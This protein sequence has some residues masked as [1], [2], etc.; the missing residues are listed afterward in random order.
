MWCVNYDISMFIPYSWTQWHL[1]PRV[2]L[3]YWLL[4]LFFISMV[5]VQCALRNSDAVR[6]MEKQR[7]L[8]VRSKMMWYHNSKVQNPSIGVFA[9]LILKSH[10][11]YYTWVDICAKRFH[12]AAGSHNDGRLVSLEKFEKNIAWKGFP[13]VPITQQSRQPGFTGTQALLPICACCNHAEEI[14]MNRIGRRRWMPCLCWSRKEGEVQDD[15]DDDADG[16]TPP[17][18]VTEC[19]ETEWQDVIDYDWLLFFLFLSPFVQLS[20][21]REASIWFL[22]MLQKWHWGAWCPGYEGVDCS[23]MC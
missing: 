8:A 18:R 1:G 5:P 23:I 16:R 20:H 14:W 11:T 19:L 22:Q 12:T 13:T 15:D 2:S 10:T 7:D 21:F 9:S 17:L 6:K 3:S 4:V